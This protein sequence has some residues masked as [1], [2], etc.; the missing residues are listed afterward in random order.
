MEKHLETK[1]L[2]TRCTEKLVGQISQIYKISKYFKLNYKK[3]QHIGSSMNF[4]SNSILNMK[5]FQ[6][7][8]FLIYNPTKIIFYFKILKLRKITFRAK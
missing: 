1:N 4:N 8:S 6:K 2:S 7:K 3:I 5:K